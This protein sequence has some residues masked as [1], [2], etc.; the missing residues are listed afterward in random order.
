ML[1]G[2][3][4]CRIRAAIRAAF[5]LLA[6]VAPLRAARTQATQVSR[7]VADWGERR[8]A[9]IRSAAGERPSTLSIR[10]IPGQR[11]PE[12]LLVDP[13]W[14]HDPFFG[15]RSL[16]II[17]APS[18]EQVSAHGI[19]APLEANGPRMLQVED[20]GDSFLDRLARSSVLTIRIGER[21]LA[22]IP[23]PQAAAAARA[24]RDC[25]DA[26]LR[27]WRVDPVAMAALQ[28]LPRPA[29]QHGELRWINDRDYPPDALR[30]GISGTVTYRFT[31]E[32]DGRVSDCTTVV[33]SGNLSLDNKAC[34][35][36]LE[37]GRF[38]PALGPDGR[39]V[40]ATSVSSLT[41]VVPHWP[42]H[43]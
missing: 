33:S 40:R 24:L 7:W 23:I 42:A 31:V 20:L 3:M 12:L 22:E 41:W 13:A 37:R 9:I 26:L 15:E 21:R 32:V 29:V 1:M 4:T 10:M 28:R 38:E 18:A 36:L 2:R 30:A 25:N 6:V 19:V 43:P 8:C 27:N 16:T 39:P 11:S 17:L 5:C 34:Q 35:V 14:A